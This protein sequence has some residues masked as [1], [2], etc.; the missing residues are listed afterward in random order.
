MTLTVADAAGNQAQIFP[1]V[2]VVDRTPP[3]L[4][5]R[6]ES[7]GYVNRR[8]GLFNVR[9]GA[10]DR[11]DPNPSVVGVIRIP[12]STSGYTILFQ[13][14]LLG[15]QIDFDVR[16]QRITL[17][18]PSEA[19]MRQLLSQVWANDGVRVNSGQTLLMQVRDGEGAPRDGRFIYSFLNGQLV[20]VSAPEFELRV[21]A[22]DASMNSAQ[23]TARPVFR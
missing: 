23:V 6:L 3:E 20:S 1:L 21:H 7:T 16:R 18:G 14:S 4:F 12:V 13:R 15:S 19:A 11:C 22:S 2:A 9:Y 10:T 8:S 5:G 17:A